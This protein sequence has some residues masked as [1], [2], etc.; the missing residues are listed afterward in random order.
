VRSARSIAGY[1][2]TVL[3]ASF[4]NGGV[5]DEPNKH[6]LLAAYASLELKPSAPQHSALR[7]TFLGV[8]TLLFDDDETAILVDGFFTRPDALRL[9]GGNVAPDPV[10]IR[11]HLERAGIKK[12]AAVI[13]LHSHIDHAMDAPE[14]ALQT[15]GLLL[16][17]ESTANIGRGWVSP[18]GK[19]PEERIRVVRDGETFSFNHFEIKIILSRHTGTAPSEGD[20]LEPLKPPVPFRSYKEGSTYKLLITH[21]GRKIMVSSSAGWVPGALEHTEAEVVFLGIPPHF[22]PD[23]PRF[24]DEYWREVVAATKVRRVIPVHWDQFWVPLDW[25][26]VPFANFRPW[27]DFLIEKGRQPPGVDIRLVPIWAKVD[28]LEGLPSKP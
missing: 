17:S 20:I 19:L 7:V 3:V 13:P 5:A 4:A 16:G 24:K 1:A 2:L 27:M 9:L 8:G 11:R 25:P 10:V 23:P 28:P 12:L 21:N 15:D 14:V 22:E 6:P 18:S 26:A